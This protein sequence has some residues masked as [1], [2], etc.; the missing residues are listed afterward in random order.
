[1]AEITKLFK[2]TVKTVKSRNKDLHRERYKDDKPSIFPATKH[3]G[4]FETTS[5]EVVKNEV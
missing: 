2:A 1:M 5:K 4:E 3:R